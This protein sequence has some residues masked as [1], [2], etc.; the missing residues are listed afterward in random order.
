M[1]QFPSPNLH[2][3]RGLISQDDGKH[4]CGYAGPL[5]DDVLQLFLIL[6]FFL[7]LPQAFFTADILDVFSLKGLYTVDFKSQNHL[8]FS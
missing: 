2:L 3:T 8:S 7:D 1:T 5:N 6:D 4:L